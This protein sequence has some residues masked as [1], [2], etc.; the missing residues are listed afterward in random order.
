MTLPGL[1][2]YLPFVDEAAVAKLVGMADAVE[3]CR[4]AYRQYG[5]G[6]VQISNPPSLFLQGIGEASARFKVKGAHL[7]TTGHVGAAGCGFRIAGD[8][9]T[10]TKEQES[11]A[12]YCYLVDPVSA[13]PLGVVAQ[14]RLN[15]MRTAA[16]GLVT[17]QAL[18][19]G[20]VRRVA[21][22]GAGRIARPFAEGLPLVF[23]DAELVVASR[24]FESASAL[25][26]EFPRH[27]IRAVP[28]IAEA[29]ADVDAIVTLSN[30]R[31]PLVDAS[32]LRPGLV[33][34]A[35][36]EHHEIA[37]GL[38]ERVDCFIVD[39]LAFACVMGTCAAWI[40]RGEVSQE[41]LAV[42]LDATIGDVIA[43]RRH[44]RRQ[45]GDT[46]LAVIQGMAALDVALAAH[47]LRHSGQA[48]TGG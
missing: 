48:R 33:V 8:V 38:L 28:T 19:R 2:G 35:M 17:L 42:R 7:R 14:T 5:E 36:G 34:L 15:R 23:P 11:E 44:G 39:D 46:V 16:S 43:G 24:R 4:A 45:P 27:A 47:C 26:D 22:L 32:A 29:I 18:A 1:S 12:H 30:A 9:G 20:P 31:S 6:L 10:S 40:G 21:L 3:I 37:V 41:A 25:R 13:R